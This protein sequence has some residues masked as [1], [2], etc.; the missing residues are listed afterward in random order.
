MGSRSPASA[1]RRVTRRNG[2]WSYGEHP[3]LNPGWRLHGTT[4]VL[5][6]DPRDRRAD[7]A[8]GAYCLW[9]DGEFR[10]SVSHYLDDAMAKIER[11]PVGTLTAH[12]STAPDV[13]QP[14]R[15]LT[16]WLRGRGAVDDGYTVADA[17]D[18]VRAYWP[19]DPTVQHVLVRL[20]NNGFAGRLGE[21]IGTA[22]GIAA[23]PVAA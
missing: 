18:A 2:L 10:E 13:Q 16:L 17:A 4:F 11:W 8:R 12:R 9:V 20:L 6:Y 21:A 5:D 3:G 1:R 19:D 7:H 22:R 15:V 14:A 23:A